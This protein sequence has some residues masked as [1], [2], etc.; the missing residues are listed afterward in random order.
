MRGLVELFEIRLEKPA[1]NN[2]QTDI[3]D[4]YR[5]IKQNLQRV[6]DNVDLESIFSVLQTIEQDTKYGDLP[7]A[8][9]HILSRFNNDMKN[10]NVF[11][12]RERNTAIKLLDLYKEFVREKCAVEH[13]LQDDNIKQ[14]YDN[15]FNTISY[16]PDEPF[17]IYTTNYD[18]VM[19]TDCKIFGP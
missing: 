15:F 17:H 9:S 16:A 1:A 3:L 13:D 5:E 6:H 10:V 11:T 4:Y 12:N 8:F 2:L 14:I 7:F 19:E 18:R